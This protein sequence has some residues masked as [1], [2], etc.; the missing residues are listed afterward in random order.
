MLVDPS[1]QVVWL[2]LMFILAGKQ[3]SCLFGGF[4]GVLRQTVDWLHGWLC[5]RHHVCRLSGLF[6]LPRLSV[7]R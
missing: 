3:Q 6:A 1:E 5:R 2:F 7:K 4:L